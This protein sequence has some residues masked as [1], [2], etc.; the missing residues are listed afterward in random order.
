ME[1]K[2]MKKQTKNAKPKPLMKALFTGADL[3][4]YI[5][6]QICKT[7]DLYVETKEEVKDP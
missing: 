4:G 5:E 2:H 1:K 3:R 6:A 7:L